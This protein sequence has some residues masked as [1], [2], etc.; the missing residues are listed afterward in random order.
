MAAA[1]QRQS[2]TLTR[3][4]SAAGRRAHL[5]RHLHA[6]RFG[7]LRRRSLPAGADRESVR[8]EGVTYVLGV[9]MNCHPCERNRPH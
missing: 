5:A 7:L 9:G 3:D 6:V 8:P 1:R 4:Q 2:V